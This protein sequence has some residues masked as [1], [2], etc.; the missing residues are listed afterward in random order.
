MS[1]PGRHCTRRATTASANGNTFD[2]EQDGGISY[3]EFA[4][5]VDVLSG[6]QNKKTKYLFQNLNDCITHVAKEINARDK[7]EIG[8]YL[9]EHDIDKNGFIPRRDF[10]NIM[11]TLK[12]GIGE[13]DI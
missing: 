13:G 1:R 4:D 6:S 12:F 5:A 2:M 3:V 11:K 8:T 7:C 9:G 10:F